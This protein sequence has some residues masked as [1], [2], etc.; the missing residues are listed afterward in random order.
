MSFSEH[1]TCVAALLPLVERATRLLATG[2]PGS[3]AG[4]FTVAHRA[5]QSAETRK[6]AAEWL[7]VLGGRALVTALETHVALLSGKKDD[8]Q[9]DSNGHALVAALFDV[10]VATVEAEEQ[11]ERPDVDGYPITRCAAIAASIARRKVNKP[12]ILERHD[13]EPE[14]WAELER[15][16]AEAIKS[17]NARGKPVL[18]SV[19]D[20]A[21]IA[22]LE[23]ERG[24]IR[25][26]DY[27]RLVVS[28]ERG[29]E[30]QTLGDLDLPRGAIPRLQRV[31]LRKTTQDKE[32][33]RL[34]RAAI[35]AGE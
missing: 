18:L 25:V 26:E 28:A 3:R 7:S 11:L 29:T 17:E 27:A 14:R 32:L 10:A 22:Q 33:A 30:Q 13:L 5:W 34:L 1:Q 20:E 24:P 35:S 8:A 4:G 19:Y 9:R 23:L 31:W 21:Y 2:A 12:T 16:W 15:H 6:E